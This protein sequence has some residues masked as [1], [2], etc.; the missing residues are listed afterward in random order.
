MILIK[1]ELLYIFT[2]KVIGQPWPGFCFLSKMK[3]K[4]MV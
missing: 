1:L 4:G 2:F 3:T